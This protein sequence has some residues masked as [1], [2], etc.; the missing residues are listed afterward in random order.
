MEKTAHRTFGTTWTAWFLAA[1]VLAAVV[2]ISNAKL[3]TGTATPVWDADAFYGPLFS[4]V[5]DHA[6]A[7]KLFLW[8]P[9]M[10]GGSPDF[11]DPQ[12]GAASPILLVFGLLSTNLLH[13]FVVYW[14]TLWVFGGVGMLLLCRHLQCPPWGGLIAAL[15]F[16]ASGFYT[17]HGQHTTILYSFSFLPWILWRFDVALARRSYWNMVLAG[18]LWGLSALGGYPALVILDPVFLGLWGVGRSWMGFPENDTAK[19]EPA[20]KRLL[21][22]VMGLC[23]FGL[24]GGA[25]MSPAYVGFLLYTKGYTSRAGG[26]SRDYAM[27]DP[28]PPQAIGTLASPFLYLLNWPPFVIWPETDVSM[29]SIYS[30][31]LVLSLAAIALTRRSRWRI[32]IGALI[33]FFLAASVGNHLPVRGWL[34]DLVPPTRYFRFPS[35]FTAYAIA[36]ICILG[37]YG[38]RDVDTLR[39]SG[40]DPG[41]WRFVAVSA[42]VA[43]VAFWAY[44][45][46]LSAAHLSFSGA[47]HPSKLLLLV[48]LPISVIFFLWWRRDISSRLLLAVLLLIGLYDASSAIKIGKATMYS[49]ATRDWWNIMVS[50]HVASLDLTPH[51]LDRQLYPPDELGRYQHDRNVVLKIPT[52]GNDTGLVNPFFQP[53]V[54]DPVLYQLALGKQRIWFT[55]NPIWLPPSDRAF[56]EYL[57]VSHTLGLPPVVLHKPAD[58]LQESASPLLRPDKDDGTWMQAVRPATPASVELLSYSPNGLSFRYDAPGDGWL[59]VTDRWARYWNATVNNRR[60]EVAGANFLFRGIPVVRGENVVQFHY[61]PRGYLGL[62]FLSW[63]TIV[64]VAVWTMIRRMGRPHAGH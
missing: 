54:A 23:I 47:G 60:V 20:G 14:M 6:K 33:L 1:C 27:V 5:A 30:G 17:G 37:A 39:V 52:L 57:K 21:F 7:G 15:G 56:E 63:G 38:A 22:V 18:V 24:V 2:L 25:V 35:L 34:Y 46:I 45:R 43:A 48:W 49:E 26:I 11:A 29:S 32:W 16:A 64:V 44:L 58:M 10:D 62:V 19:L 55:D 40:D 4:L 28:L 9:W 13:G 51:G 61:E 31:A 41:R 59:L 12:I 53:Y 36:G 42:A 3:L 8:N 50:R